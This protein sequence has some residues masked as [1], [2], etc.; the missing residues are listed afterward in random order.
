MSVNKLTCEVKN[1]KTIIYNI[2]SSVPY[3]LD[4]CDV[5]IICTY[6]LDTVIPVPQHNNKQKTVIKINLCD[7]NVAQF[8]CYLTNETWDIVYGDGVQK[9]LAWFQGL[10]DLLFDKC[11]PKQS[12]ILTYQNRYKWMTNILRTQ[13][14]KRKKLWSPASCNPDNFN[15]KNEYKQR[16][17]SLISDLRNAEIEY[18]SN[19]LDIHKNYVKQSWKILK[20]IIGKHTTII[21]LKEK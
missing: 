5:G 1:S 18:Y 20:T 21:T 10:I 13:I 16:R 17:N 4:M 6:G 19:E 3:A 8:I 12:H 2:F 11:F 14:S 15:L 9:A 7:R